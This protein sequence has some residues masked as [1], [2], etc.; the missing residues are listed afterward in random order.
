MRIGS[1]LLLL[2][3]VFQNSISA[4]DNSFH[5]G[6]KAGINFSMFNVSKFESPVTGIKND[7]GFYAGLQ[8]EARLNK[9]FSLQPEIFYIENSA[10]DYE[11]TG[12]SKRV[13]NSE[14]L[15]HISIPILAK[16]HAG[17]FGFYV[18]PQ[19]SL[20]VKATTF[21]NSIPAEVDVT[22]KS[23]TKTSWS[24]VFGIEYVF[25]H[26]FGIDA[27]YQLGLS[28]SRDSDGITALTFPDGQ[29]IKLNGFQTGLFFRF[30]KKP[31]KQDSPNN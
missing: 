19:I 4:Q 10:T 1:T 7:N 9:K 27:R 22:D 18:G 29:N 23:Y 28:N 12:A 24:G 11:G 15:K 5:V 31:K 21:D 13:L 2:I 26:R 16:L 25:K 17:K 20:L 6:P 14:N 8:F 30:G 3:A